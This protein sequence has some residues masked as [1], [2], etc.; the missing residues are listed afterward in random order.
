MGVVLP[1][2]PKAWVNLPNY[3]KRHVASVQVLINNMVM[4]ISFSLPSGEAGMTII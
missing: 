3:R 4:A 1:T 2:L